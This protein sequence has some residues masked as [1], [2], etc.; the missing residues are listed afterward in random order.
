[1]SVSGTAMTASLSGMVAA[2]AAAPRPD[3][4]SAQR[5][6]VLR[7]ARA[8][9]LGSLPTW[10]AAGAAAPEVQEGCGLV[11]ATGSFTARR[12]ELGSMLRSLRANKGLTAEQ[13]AWRLGVSRS[14]IS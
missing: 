3:L 1:M 6:L 4:G 7:L 5:L 12:R 8:S 9:V 2:A 10:S 13:V 11:A 14:K